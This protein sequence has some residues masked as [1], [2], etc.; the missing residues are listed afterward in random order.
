MIGIVILNYNNWDDTV[1]CIKSI[2]KNETKCD[3]HIYVV[4]N[5]SPIPAS[6]DVKDFLNNDSRI[7]FIKNIEN[8]GYSAG[9]N[10]GIKKALK[11]G[12]KEILISNNDV[13]Y[14]R[15]SIYL[16]KKFL[17]DNPSVGIVGPK[18]FKP[19]GNLQKIQ[20]GIKYDLKGKYLNILSKTIFSYF[21]K[22]FMNE[23]YA[24]DKDLT[25]PLEVFAVFGCSFMMSEKC[26]RDITPFDENT[27]LY[28]EELIIGVTMEKYGY[29]TVIFPESQIIHAHGQST[30]NVKAFSYTCLVE[31]EIYYLRRYI[32]SSV[33]SI[34]PLYLIRTLK[35]LFLAIKYKDFRKNLTSY[36]K[37]TIPKF[38]IKERKFIH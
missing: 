10:V 14:K 18:I 34:L 4:D 24:L 25:K 1:K 15:D 35:Y 22:H 16:M 2:F 38:R 12:C 27:F 19:D 23:F 8:R 33:L 26:A 37:R 17:E 36:F 28:E 30:K 5:A 3:Y 20:F 9:N 6:K 29:K 31:S 21:T 7:T 32:N 13:I 11:D